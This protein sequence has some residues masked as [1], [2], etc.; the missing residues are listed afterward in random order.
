MRKYRP[1]IADKILKEKL[2]G[3]GAVLIEGAKWCGKTTSASQIAKSILYMQDPEKVKQN[4]ELAEI[5]PS[6]LLEGNTPR[7]IDE[8]QMAP[9]LWDAIRF[10]VDQRDAFG[11]F[12]L[13]GSSVPAD[14]SKVYHSGAGRITKM[15]MRPMSLFES[16]DS[17]GTVSLRKLFGGNLDVDGTNSIDIEMLS[18]LICRGGWPKSLDCSE[19]VALQQAFDYYSVIVDTDISKV[20]NVHRN[21]GRAHRLMRAYARFI[22]SQATLQSISNDL[23][24]NEAQTISD[25]T[26]SSYINALKRIFVIEDSSAWNPNLRSKTAIRSSDTRYFTDPSIG[27]AALGLGPQDLINDLNTLGLFFE[28]LCVRDLRVY[29]ESL[30]GNLYHYRDRSG[31]ECDAVVHLHNGLYGLIEIKLG[32][33]TRIL[34]GVE[35]LNKLESNIDTS[36]MKAPSFKMVLT[37]TGSYAYKRLDGVLIVPIGCLR[38]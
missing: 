26:I 10:S 11:Q 35:T 3:K 38:N 9:Q 37:G 34:E 22:G 7:L 13:T 29:A 1:R 5:K 30:D 21:K 33:E 12:I 27:V 28:N 36:K 8:W 23:Q 17:S 24:I 16:E 14:T 25:D 32:G 31:L 15:L 18:F 4:L 19:K 6:K 2:E 20:D